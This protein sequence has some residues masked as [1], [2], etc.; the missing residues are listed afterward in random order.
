MTDKIP[1]SFDPTQPD[2]PTKAVDPDPHP[3]SGPLQDEETPHTPET[4]QPVPLG[5][6]DDAR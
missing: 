5:S 3:D 1:D 2:L 4:D 6:E